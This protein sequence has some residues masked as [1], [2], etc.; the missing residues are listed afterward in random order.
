MLRQLMNDPQLGERARVLLEPIAQPW[1]DVIEDIGKAEA[2]VHQPAEQQLVVG[3]TGKIHEIDAALP[4]DARDAPSVVPEDARAE[5]PDPPPTGTTR[6]DSS[7]PNDLHIRRNE[8]AQLRLE[9]LLIELRPNGQD[10]GPPTV[11]RKVGRKLAG[12]M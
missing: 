3:R 5:I 2:Q 7:G 6:P 12:P 10:R 1:I 11:L 9:R 8:R 4:A